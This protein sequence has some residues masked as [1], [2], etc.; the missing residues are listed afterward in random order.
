MSS[1]N[2]NRSVHIYSPG[3]RQTADIV[4]GINTILLKKN[5]SKVSFN[6]VFAVRQAFIHSINQSIDAWLND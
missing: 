3:L 1:E 2:K 6:P 4:Y 5:L